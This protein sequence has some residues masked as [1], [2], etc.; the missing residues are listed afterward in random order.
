MTD[1]DTTNEALEAETY[2]SQLYVNWETHYDEEYDEE[3]HYLSC[4]EHA[5]CIS[6]KNQSS[7]VAV[8]KFD[9]LVRLENKT[10][11]MDVA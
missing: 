11:E 9:R 1:N 8:Y 2:P 6:I 7:L 3:H 10:T 4:D 5:D